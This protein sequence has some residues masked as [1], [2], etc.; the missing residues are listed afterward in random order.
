MAARFVII[1]AALSIGFASQAFSAIT[2]TT[3]APIKEALANLSEMWGEEPTEGGAALTVKVLRVVNPQTGSFSV[4]VVN[5]DGVAC[6]ID[7][8]M[9]RKT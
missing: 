4:L 5:K 6:L 8:G 3:C 1:T 2:S 9:E 7:S